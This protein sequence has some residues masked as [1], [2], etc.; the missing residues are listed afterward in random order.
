MNHAA[1]FWRI[2]MAHMAALNGLA[3]DRHKWATLPD[4]RR[5][6]RRALAEA[7]LNHYFNEIERIIAQRSTP[8]T[9]WPTT[10][11]IRQQSRPTR[12]APQF[13]Y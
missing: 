2:A 4:W 9:H 13:R 1:M 5:R 8:D 6:E 10:S 7:R 12:Q 3:A 11:D